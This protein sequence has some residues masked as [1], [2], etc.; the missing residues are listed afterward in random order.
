MKNL[1][2]MGAG[3][4]GREIAAFIDDMNKTKKEWNILGFLETPD[5]LGQKCGNYEVIG[6]DDDLM[7]LYESQDVWAVIAMQEGKIRKK[8]VES[9]PDFKQWA[10]IIHPSA[11]LIDKVDVGEGTVISPLAAI[12]TATSIGKHCFISL[13]VTIGHDGQIGDYCSIMPGAALDGHVSLGERAYIATNASVLPGVSIGE[14]TLLGVGSVAM[15]DI[16]DHVTAFG[17]PAKPMMR[18]R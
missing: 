3:D 7:S 15:E 13:G 5:K 6:V 17:N 10:T 12:S 8:I 18:R 9:Q 1:V 16:R 11:V 14:N 4:C 2:I